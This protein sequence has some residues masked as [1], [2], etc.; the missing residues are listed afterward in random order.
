MIFLLNNEG[1]MCNRIKNFAHCLAYGIDNNISVYNCV[2][3]EYDNF[4]SHNNISIDVKLQKNKVLVIFFSILGRVL[5]K[6]SCSNKMIRIFKHRVIV[7]P[8][9]YDWNSLF[10][11]KEEVLKYLKFKDIYIEKSQK[12]ISEIKEA[13][14]DFVLVGVHIRRGDYLKWRN[15]K[16]FFNNDEY[17]N[18]FK[19]IASQNDKKC[20]FVICTNDQELKC[21]E[22]KSEEY[23]VYLSGCD[24]VTDLL[25]LSYCDL[26][27]GPPSTYSWWAAF[28]GDVKYLTLIDREM[29]I[30]ISEFEHIGDRYVKGNPYEVYKNFK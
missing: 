2:W 1:Q 20:V 15:G 24:Q 4:F 10:V 28:L 14:K 9:F 23:D 16:Y 18:F 27:I 3:G 26:I 17:I 19:Q 6:F 21:S 5:K 29:T 12:R 25:V 11:H 13:Y 7:Q 22:L 8:D 30:E